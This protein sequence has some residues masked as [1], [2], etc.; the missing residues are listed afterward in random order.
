[1][2][3]ERLPQA[4]DVLPRPDWPDWPD[5]RSRSETGFWAPNGT[6]N[7]VVAKLNAAVVE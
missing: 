6:P 5:L 4:P 3:K 1:L 2:A 7:D